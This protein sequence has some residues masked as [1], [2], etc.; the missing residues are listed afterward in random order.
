MSETTR[1]AIDAMGGDY[2][3]EE[4]VKGAVIGARQYGV[5]IL[6]V[7]LPDVVRR[8]L[9][10]YDTE[11]LDIGIVPATEVIEM[12]EAPANA[13]RKKRD[14]SVSVTARLVRDG[15]AQAMIAAGSTGA[16]MA[17][18]TLIIG[19]LHGVDRP[20]IGVVLPSME[21]PCML[22][23][24][25]ANADCI[26]EMLLQFA[27]MG[28]TFMQ[29]VLQIENPRVG[30]LNIGE[31]LGK[32]NTLVNAAFELM[33]HDSSLNFVG[34]IEGNNL[35]LGGVDV[36]VCDGFVG[37]VALKSAEG[38]SKMLLKNIKQE[39][40]SG[41]IAKTGA[42]LARDALMQAKK[43]VD[44]GEH[45]GALLLGIKGVCVIGHG[46]SDANAIKNAI[47]V[48]KDA[49]QTDI[50]GKIGGRILEG[51]TST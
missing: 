23:D 4:I 25:G 3:P 48:A 33:E 50:L 38:V 40:N 51:T 34:N 18:A 31:E 45:G 46:S 29:C 15:E 22:L 17:A 6:L 1:I 42:L 44:P 20:A 32:G 47:R 8:E 5:K 21:S 13:I 12:G 41:I 36:A 39:L 24:A 9:D 37:N 2:A 10:R 11:G 14:S 35:F 27:R 49:V 16:A 28:S 7:G 19:R 26:P 30:I 43:K